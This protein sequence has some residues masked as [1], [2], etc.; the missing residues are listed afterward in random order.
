MMNGPLRFIVCLS[1]IQYLYYGSKTPMT[2][3]AL[4]T[5]LSYKASS[6]ETN[7]IQQVYNEIWS[8]ITLNPA[9]TVKI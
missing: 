5:V 1:Q 8:K 3:I 2:E 7:K 4:K 9:A 6:L